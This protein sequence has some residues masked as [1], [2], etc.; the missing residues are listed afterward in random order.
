MNKTCQFM[1]S[2]LDSHW[3]AVKWIIR[4][5]NSTIPHGLLLWLINSNFMRIEISTR[6][7][8]LTTV[9]PLMV[10][11]FSLVPIS[12]HG[13]LRRNLSWLA[14]AL[15]LSI[16]PLLP[17]SYGLWF[18]LIFYIFFLLLRL[19]WDGNIYILKLWIM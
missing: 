13:T 2:P 5:L 6:K 4:Y 1:S 12:Y 3:E 16:V 10:C 11:V 18:I 15:K 17:I 8:T 9:D 7:A 19:T 14:L